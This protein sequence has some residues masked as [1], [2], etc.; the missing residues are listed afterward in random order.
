MSASLQPSSTL[1]SPHFTA[2]FLSHLRGRKDLLSIATPS[3]YLCVLLVLK[4]HFD[5]K[6]PGGVTSDQ[7]CY[8]T[9][10]FTKHNNIKYFLWIQK[11]Q[12]KDRWNFMTW[13]KCVC[14][15]LIQRVKCIPKT[16]VGKFLLAQRQTFYFLFLLL[17]LY[18]ADKTEQKPC[19]AVHWS[20]WNAKKLKK[21]CLR[22]GQTSTSGWGPGCSSKFP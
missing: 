17:K 7:K 15:V 18:L 10:C 22:T 4:F 12:N 14:H 21:H 1:A 11:A 16:M 3:H 20:Q 8:L 6:E 9:F 13:L 2:C 5:I 19:K